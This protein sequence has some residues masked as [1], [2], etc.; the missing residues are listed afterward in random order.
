ML[1]FWF[2]SYICICETS[3]PLALCVPRYINTE[4]CSK[5]L[6]I[7]FW[8]CVAF[9]GLPYDNDEQKQLVFLHDGTTS[10]T[11]NVVF[12]TFWEMVSLSIFAFTWPFLILTISYG[13]SELVMQVLVN[14]L[15][16]RK[17]MHRC[18]LFHLLRKSHP[19][20][21]W[22]GL[23]NALS[24]TCLFFFVLSSNR[25]VDNRFRKPTN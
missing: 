10:P 25:F 2:L 6:L 13:Q 17:V 20:E 15:P 21:N 18:V 3:C 12:S 1:L 19:F 4:Y 5:S 7:T 11:L 14:Y 24:I 8:Y 9:R 16:F 23:T 22:S